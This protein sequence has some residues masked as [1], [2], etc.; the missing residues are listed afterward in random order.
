VVSLPEILP[1]GGELEVRRVECVVI[2]IMKRSRDYRA[3]FSLIAVAFCFLQEKL[4]LSIWCYEC[5]TEVS[6]S[7]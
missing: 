4:K 7:Q 2:A 1:K 5:F 6:F 3:S